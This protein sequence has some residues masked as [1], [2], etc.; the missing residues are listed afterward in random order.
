PA[1]A[2]LIP[3]ADRNSIADVDLDHLLAVHLA[4][5]FVLQSRDELLGLRVED[6]ASTWVGVAA[7]EGEGDPA[8]L[9]PQRQAMRLPRRGRR[10]VEDV[11]PAIVGVADPGL[12]L[13]RREADAVAGAAVPLHGALLVALNLDALEYLAARQVG[14]FEAE[15]LVDTDVCA[16]L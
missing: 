14:D 9:L 11:Q 13:V 3:V 2:E 15:Q 6:L 16:R 8:G 4:A 1:D 5:G 12:G 7:V 10:Q